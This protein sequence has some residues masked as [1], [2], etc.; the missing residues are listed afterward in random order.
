MRPVLEVRDQHDREIECAIHQSM[1]D[2]LTRQLDQFHGDMRIAAGKAGVVMRQET[3]T[4]GRQSNAGGIAAEEITRR[5][6]SN[7]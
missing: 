2:R 4:L 1:L 5:S 6:A 3:G 7:C